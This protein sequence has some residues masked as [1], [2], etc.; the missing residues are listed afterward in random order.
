MLYL[1][2][3]SWLI[4]YTVELLLSY[5]SPYVFINE[6][7]CELKLYNYKNNFKYC[8]FIIHLFLFLE[9]GIFLF[10]RFILGLEK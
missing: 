2:L 6:N 3:N 1:G 4:T 10:Q 5:F 8:N 7:T 9:G